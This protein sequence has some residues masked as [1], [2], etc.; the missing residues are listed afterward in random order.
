VVGSRYLEK[1]RWLFTHREFRRR[2]VGV[3]GAVA[4]WEWIR[5]R[6]RP[7]IL[8]LGPFSVI[9]RPHD[10]IGRLICYFG[11]GADEVLLFIRRYIT[12]GMTV[13]DVGANIGTHSL[14]AARQTGPTG[15]VVAFEPE[16][17]TANVLRSNVEWNGVKAIMEIR[18]AGLGE[19]KGTARLNV[20]KDSAKSSL[21]RE[22]SS[23][24]EV[25]LESLDGAFEGVSIDLLKIDVEG[26][27][28]EVLSGGRSLFEHTPPACVVIEVTERTEEIREFFERYGY[29]LLSYQHN[30]DTFRE[31]RASDLNCYAVHSRVRMEPAVGGW[32]LSTW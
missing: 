15:R 19:S 16:P 23:T 17:E 13:V 30:D 18:A 28:Y 8:T 5:F 12:E 22:G 29:R 24:V 2:P 9:A 3:L 20:N 21:V 14:Y 6:G 1:A 7:A 10:G 26:A 27:D 4:R 32:R 31:F 25:R 11:E